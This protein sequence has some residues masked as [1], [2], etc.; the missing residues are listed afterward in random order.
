MAI[1]EI[2][3]GPKFSG[4]LSAAR[5]VSIERGRLLEALAGSS[6]NYPL[7]PIPHRTAKEEEG[8]SFRSTAAAAAAG[9]GAHFP[10]GSLALLTS[11]SADSLPF[12]YLAL[13]PRALLY[14]GIN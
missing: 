6:R 11:S 8:K 14:M 13:V 5:H 1:H 9:S 2:K 4:A 3:G 7:I 10:V 12:V